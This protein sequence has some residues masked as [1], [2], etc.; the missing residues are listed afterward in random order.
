MSAMKL[1]DTT[2][3]PAVDRWVAA[4]GLGVVIW[5]DRHQLVVLTH[6]A[7]VWRVQSHRASDESATPWVHWRGVSYEREGLDLTTFD[8]HASDAEWDLI[9]NRRWSQAPHVSVA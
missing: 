3:K 1:S 4:D 9:Y 5:A 2:L 6:D 7:G 8:K